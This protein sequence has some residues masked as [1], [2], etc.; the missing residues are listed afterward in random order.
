MPGL[1]LVDCSAGPHGWL[2]CPR[3][4]PPAPNIL[5]AIGLSPTCPS[6]Q[7]FSEEGAP[8]ADEYVNLLQVGVRGRWKV[9]MHFSRKAKIDLFFDPKEWTVFF[10]G[11]APG[12][13]F[14]FSGIQEVSVAEVLAEGI[15]AQGVL[16]LI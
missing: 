14:L 6:D 2:C 7:G 5:L 8:Q 12:K 4:P 9:R 3:P 15:V 13:H 1:V 16:L 10:L 11:Q